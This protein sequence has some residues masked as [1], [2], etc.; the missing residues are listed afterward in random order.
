MSMMTRTQ[1][2]DARRNIR[3]QIVPWISI[4][5][6]GMVSLVAYLSLVYSAEAIQRTISAYYDR[7]RFWDL[8]ISSTLLMDDDDLRAIHS[9]PGVELA[10]PVRQVNTQILAE[11]AKESTAAA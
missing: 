5:V 9:I 6:I 11:G 2:T 8:E 1:L 4:V 10:E 7:Y 3:K